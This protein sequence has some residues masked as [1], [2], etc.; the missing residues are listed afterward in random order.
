MKNHIFQLAVISLLSV[1]M[2]VIAKAKAGTVPPES[3]CRE[4]KGEATIEGKKET[5]TVLKCLDEQGHWVIA[6]HV[7]TAT[8]ETIVIKP[9]PS[10]FYSSHYPPVIVS[11]DPIFYPVPILSF[12]YSGGWHGHHHGRHGY[13]RGR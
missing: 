1:P 4:V 13:R 3:I 10:Y 2:M 5:I 12:G 7:T 11:T 8:S 6:N 9:V